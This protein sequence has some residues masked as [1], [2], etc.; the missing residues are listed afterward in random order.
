[1][2]NTGGWILNSAALVASC[3]GTI[4]SA[5]VLLCIVSRGRRSLDNNLLL[6]ANTFVPVLLCSS[7]LAS[8]SI[9]TLLGDS[10]IYEYPDSIACQ[11]RG[12]LL[13][14]AFQWLFLSFGLQALGRLFNVIYYQQ[15]APL[16]S[17]LITKI[18]IAITPFI[19][20]VL[21]GPHIAIKSVIYEPDEFQCITN[22]R[23]WQNYTY[24]LPAMYLGPISIVVA[25][26]GRVI[27]AVRQSSLRTSNR[28]QQS[29]SRDMLILKRIVFI[30]TAL[31]ILGVPTLSIWLEWIFTKRLNSLAYRVQAMT[32]SVSM[33]VLSISLALINPQL[34]IL[35]GISQN[36]RVVPIVATIQTL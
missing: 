22:F 24:M 29:M 31:V 16:R 12:Y 15:Q 7:I 20:L 30:V 13:L 36:N 27:I 35:L 25:S 19:S 8:L 26:Y 3:L 10:I 2:A 28:R 33:L 32:L 1:M 5:I 18:S 17:L 34:K 11:V 14:Y 23:M 6:A 9:G 4:L 21:F